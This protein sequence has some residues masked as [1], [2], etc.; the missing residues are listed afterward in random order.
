MSHL[1]NT[2]ALKAMPSPKGDKGCSYES[3]SVTPIDNGFLVR[4]SCDSDGSYKSTE[5]FT[6]ERPQLLVPSEAPQKSSS[7]SDAVKSLKG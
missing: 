6:P 3:V 7:M 2:A 5:Y 4:K 1:N